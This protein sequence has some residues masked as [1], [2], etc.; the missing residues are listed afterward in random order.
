MNTAVQIQEVRIKDITV[1]ED[2]ITAQTHGWANNQ[3]STGLV[4]A[5]IGGNAQ[6]AGKLGNHRRWSWRALARHR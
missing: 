4:V 1:T 5:V 2:T 3:C 6:T